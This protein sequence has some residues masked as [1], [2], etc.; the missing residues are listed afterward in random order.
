MNSVLRISY[1]SHLLAE[2]CSKNQLQNY[3]LLPTLGTKSLPYNVTKLLYH[4]RKNVDTHNLP[5][6]TGITLKSQRLPSA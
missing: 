5:T 2:T 6:Y 1:V 3:V 4:P